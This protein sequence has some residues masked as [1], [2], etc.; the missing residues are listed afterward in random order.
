[1]SVDVTKH[2]KS[3]HMCQLQSKTK[4]KNNPMK[5]REILTIPSE[6]VA[7]DIVG[8]FPKAKGGFQYL[9]TSINAAT[10][11]PEA[12]AVKTVTANVIVRQL[13]LMNGFLAVIVSDNGT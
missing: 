13:K 1:M 2:I 8:P 10:R 6:R 9:F 3:C 7:I 4:P 11:W 12:I 5:E